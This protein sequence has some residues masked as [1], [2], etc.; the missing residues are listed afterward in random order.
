LIVYDTAGRRVA[1]LR[2]GF[3]SAG[4]RKSVVWNG[5]T[6]QGERAASGVYYYRLQSP[7][8]DQTYRMVLVQ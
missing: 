1:T 6:D 2:N 3:E 5:R 4:L 8:F 7:G